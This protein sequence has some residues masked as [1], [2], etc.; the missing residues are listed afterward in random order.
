MEEAKINKKSDGCTESF[1]H[2]VKRIVSAM[3]LTVRY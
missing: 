3:L 2:R 1:E